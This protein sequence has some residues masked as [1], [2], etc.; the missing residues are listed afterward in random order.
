[1]P[2]EIPKLKNVLRETTEPAWMK[3]RVLS[4]GR[5]AYVPWRNRND[6]DIEF[7]EKKYCYLAG[8]VLDAGLELN[9][10]IRP[11]YVDCVTALVSEGLRQYRDELLFLTPDKMLSMHQDL[12][13]W[14]ETATDEQIDIKAREL[15]DTIISFYNRHQ[16]HP[17]FKVYQDCVQRLILKGFNNARWLDDGKPR[18]TGDN[19]PFLV[20][21]ISARSAADAENVT[22]A[23]LD[24]K[25]MG[26]K[27]W[28]MQDKTDDITNRPDKRIRA[29]MTDIA[30]LSDLHI[31]HEEPQL[32]LARLWYVAIVVKDNLTA[33]CGLSAYNGVP[34]YRCNYPSTAD[35]KL[36]D[37]NLAMIPPKRGCAENG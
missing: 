25:R 11:A 18:I 10:D 22:F 17:D 33:C 2:D 21:A 15:A 8:L 4:A 6:R 19:S 37:I 1:M 30:W 14:E 28:V 36:R 24:A 9:P 34:I 3:R 32:L 23:E 16:N 5:S 29:E 12:A 26:D 13:A 7:P 35:Y 20:W 27:Y 31:S